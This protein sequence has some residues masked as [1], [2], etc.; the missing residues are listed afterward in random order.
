MRIT[1]AAPFL[2]RSSYTVTFTGAAT[3]G[4]QG[5]LPIFTVTGEVLVVAFVPYSITTPEGANS[6]ILLGVTSD[7]NL[8]SPTGVTTLTN[9]TG[10]KFLMDNTVT[11][12]GVAL[13]A[14]NKDIVITDNI[15]GTIATADCTG[16]SARFDLYWMPLSSDGNVT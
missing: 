11:A 12:N 15:I 6:T 2:R 14:G 7:T 1:Q 8:F 9:W 5:A 3:L 16:G 10:G 4:A 13:A